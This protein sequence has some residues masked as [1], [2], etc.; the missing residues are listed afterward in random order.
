M[1]KKMVFLFSLL[2]VMA[3]ATAALAAPEAGVTAAAMD[4]IGKIA[5]AAGI[6]IGVATLG[7][8]IGQGLAIFSA[9]SGIARNP[10]AA[11]TIRVNM[12]IGLALLESL[13]IYGLVVALILLYAFPLSGLIT[14]LFA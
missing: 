11:G 3:T 10:E 9:L 14:G 7:P 12:L 5:I 1:K 8:G 4:A 6:A 13:V 2:A